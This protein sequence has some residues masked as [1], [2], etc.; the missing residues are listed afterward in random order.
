MSLVDL[1]A[2]DCDQLLLT[3]VLRFQLL[4]MQCKVE[5]M[6]M[7]VYLQTTCQLPRRDLGQGEFLVQRNLLH[8]IV[9]CQSAMVEN[10]WPGCSA[11]VQT[12]AV[13]RS[14]LAW[15]AT[16]HGCREALS[17]TGN[18]LHHTIEAR[19]GKILCF[20]ISEQPLSATASSC[21]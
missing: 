13:V 8:H 17:A 19:S 3:I 1:P 7:I 6:K 21:F 10:I 11:F 5:S 20:S 18:M 4:T 9:G 12:L 15:V 16:R 2:L 14:F